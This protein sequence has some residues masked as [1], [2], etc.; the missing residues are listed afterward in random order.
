MSTAPDLQG[1][2]ARIWGFLTSH[3]RLVDII[4]AAGYTLVMLPGLIHEIL[5][6]TGPGWAAGVGLIATLAAGGT[7]LFRRRTPMLVLAV[8]FVLAMVK[9]LLCGLP[10]PLGLALAGYAAGAHLRPGR[11][12]ITIPAVTGATAAMISIGAPIAPLAGPVDVLLVL[13]L[14]PLVPAGLLGL[15][16]HTL[17][18]LSDSERQRLL[19]E[20]HERRQAMELLAAQERAVLSREMHDVVGHTLTAIINVSDGALRAGGTDTEIAQD[21]LRRIN[22]VARDALGETRAILSSQRPAG[23][24]APRFPARSTSMPSLVSMADADLNELLRTAES[25]GMH[26]SLTVNEEP[27]SPELDKRTQATVYRIVQEAIT[28]TMRH[29]QSATRID[30]VL[31]HGPTEI[32]L[33]VLDNG[34]PGTTNNGQGQGLRG[35]TERATL[36]GGA[37]H[38]GPAPA[39]G[40]HVTAT[41][42]IPTT[43]ESHV[44]QR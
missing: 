43:H 3:S 30:V 22:T 37:A 34:M 40:W 25:T 17:S 8:V 32:T 9:T 12:W 13:N 21:S 31:D 1:P 5:Q 28:N 7:L 26:T 2:P 27:A 33:E 20:E 24:A 6:G 36:L 29:A 4:I 11:S 23:P 38:C 16:V 39:G 44:Q 19:Q 18:H 14:V 10:D 35:L 15:L 41:L 42:P